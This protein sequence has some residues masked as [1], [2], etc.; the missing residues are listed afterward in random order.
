[1]S[2]SP[3]RISVAPMMD[4]TDRHCRYFMRLI[5]PGVRLYTEM[6][7]AEALLR[8][9][10]GR[11]L[12]RDPAESPVAL[13]LGGSNPDL[14]ARATE[15]AAP[16]GYDE[17]N[18]NIGCPSDRVRSGRFGACLMLDPALVADCVGA[19]RGAADVPVTVKT[20]TGID[21][22]DD[23]EF[24]EDF[25]TTV[26]ATGWDTF[27]VHARNAIL[28]GLSPKQN[29]EIPPLRYPHVYRLK[30]EFPSLTVIVNGGISESGA[31]RQHLERVDGVMI[32]RKAYSDP[33]FLHHLQRE[34]ACSGATG[35]PGIADRGSVVLAM[36]DYA[37]R[38]LSRGT[39][40]HHITRHML[41][42]YSGQA[43]ARSWRRYL[44][45][46][47]S[48]TTAGPEVLR[49]SLKLLPEAA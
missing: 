13:Q 6:V 19:I 36:A 25:V 34:F 23:Y 9:D 30:A 5:A 3:Q 7:T 21:E 32:G 38:E 37:E 40:L 26:A 28:G 17:I 45:E 39:R 22:R 41:G 15:A 4:R 18:L 1:M 24:L 20:R 8:G 16:F 27:I 48:G 2:A 47:A 11:L 46:H 10:T 29:R 44:C 35:S 33:W 14:L 31:V 43:G 12:E 49:E 42:L